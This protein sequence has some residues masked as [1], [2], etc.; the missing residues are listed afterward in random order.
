MLKALFFLVTMLVS[1]LK[2]RRDLALENL[3]FRQQLAV[4]K[5]SCQRP[6]LRKTDRLF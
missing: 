1:T 2:E 4:F 6:Q 5:R 3:V